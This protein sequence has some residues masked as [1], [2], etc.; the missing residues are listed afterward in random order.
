M[1]TSPK[2]NLYFNPQLFFYST[3]SAVQSSRARQTGAARAPSLAPAPWP[4]AFGA[5]GW[6]RVCMASSSSASEEESGRRCSQLYDE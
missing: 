5:V 2:C 1:H 3:G 4:L 6:P